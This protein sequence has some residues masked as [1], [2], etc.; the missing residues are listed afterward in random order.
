MNGFTPLLMTVHISSLFPV[1]IFPWVAQRGC[2]WRESAPGPLL[3]PHARKAVMDHGFPALQWDWLLDAY[4]ERRKAQLI[5]DLS[6]H[7]SIAD[8]RASFYRFWW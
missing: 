3:L 8:M 2:S 5:F 4:D 1:R 6:L 7:F